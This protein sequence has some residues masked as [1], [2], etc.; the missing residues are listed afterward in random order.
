MIS[1][2]QAARRYR[3]SRPELERFLRAARAAAGLKGSVDVL[4]TGDE[5]IRGLNKKFR[6][7]DKPTDVL[8]FP[9]LQ[10]AG[11]AGKTAGASRTAG[12]LAISV[13]TAAV[14]AKAYGHST[15]E[16]AKI[17]MLHGVL[18]LAGH[19][20]AHDSGEMQRL[21]EKLRR[22]LKLPPSLT[23]RAQGATR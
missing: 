6:G 5:E 14:Q 13:E 8:S 20:H 12:D 22:Q 11:R 15:M 18:H 1:I 3:L 7:K 17:L 9:A 16:E 10:A 2:A 19:D 4:L 21:E 23:E